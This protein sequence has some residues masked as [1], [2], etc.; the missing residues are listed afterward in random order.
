MASQS[1]IRLHDL[2]IPV[3]TLGSGEEF[4]YYGFDHLFDRAMPHIAGSFKQ[5]PIRKRRYGLQ[6]S[7]LV[8][9]LAFLVLV[10]AI[11][12]AASLAAWQSEKG[13]KAQAQCDTD[14]AYVL[15]PSIEA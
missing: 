12:I 2:P 1:D 15:T 13:K 3:E 9:S 5:T 4:R 6:K 10:L 14:K 7:T 8:L 11:I